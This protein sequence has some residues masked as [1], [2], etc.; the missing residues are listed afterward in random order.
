METEKW[1]NNLFKDLNKYFLS[2]MGVLFI[3]A[4]F[5]GLYMK[6]KTESDMLAMQV[7][8]ERSYTS[9]AKEESKKSQELF[10]ECHEIL[11]SQ[12][13]RFRG[14]HTLKSIICQ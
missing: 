3:I 13:L 4:V 8:E 2:I 11:E 12:N 6:E 7:L 5:L 9:L 14:G 10:C 1:Q